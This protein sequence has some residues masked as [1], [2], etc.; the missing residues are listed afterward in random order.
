MGSK[1]VSIEILRWGN[2]MDIQSE[3]HLSRF[4]H[5]CVIHLSTCPLPPNSS[6]KPNQ[7][8]SFWLK[9][10]GVCRY[11]PVTD[12]KFA[13][14]C[15]TVEEQESELDDI[16]RKM[17]ITE[18]AISTRFSTMDISTE[19]PS[20]PP[21]GFPSSFLPLNN[22]LKEPTLACSRPQESPVAALAS[23]ENLALTQSWDSDE[24]STDDTK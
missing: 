21:S 22:G 18:E 2:R 19:K 11:S 23:T 14:I 1:F 15:P 24:E 6:E 5:K 20:P 12:R 8:I 7:P 3:Q 13:Q 4:A 10:P 9:K 17:H 16:P